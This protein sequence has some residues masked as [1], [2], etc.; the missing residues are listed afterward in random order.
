MGIEKIYHRLHCGLLHGV[1]A[2]VKGHSEGHG[3][4][5]K[6]RPAKRVIGFDRREPNRSM[7]TVKST[8]NE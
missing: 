4:L 5:R 3:D 2:R 8:F 1:D 7:L 6:V